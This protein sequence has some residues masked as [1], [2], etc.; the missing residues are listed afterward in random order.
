[1]TDSVFILNES[2]QI[3]RNKSE[4]IMY[5]KRIA[6]PFCIENI[7]NICNYAFIAPI[8]RAASSK[9]KYLYAYSLKYGQIV[10]PQAICNAQYY[11]LSA[12][13]FQ[14]IANN[15]T[16][17]RAYTRSNMRNRRIL[18]KKKITKGRLLCN[19]ARTTKLCLSPILHCSQTITSCFFF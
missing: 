4:Y 15:S 3:Q 13:S 11:R 17:N 14:K 16:T 10:N 8:T 2:Q 18:Q 9:T 5:L 6:F 1:M 7:T 19:A 12:I